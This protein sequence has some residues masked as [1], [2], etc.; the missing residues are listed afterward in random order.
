MLSESPTGMVF[1]TANIKNI[2]TKNKKA[3]LNAILIADFIIHLEPKQETEEQS[4]G[5]TENAQP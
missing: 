5:Q 1:L 4:N 3:S 2:Q